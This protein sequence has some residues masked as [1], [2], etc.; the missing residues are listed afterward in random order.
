MNYYVNILT[1]VA[2]NGLLGLSVY[3]VLSTGQLTLGNAGFMGVGAFASALLSMHSGLPLFVSVLVGALIAMVVAIP[4]GY[5]TLR[6][7]GINL[8]IVTLGF[9]QIVVVVAQNVEYF[10]GALGLKNIPQ[11][12]GTV[13][14]LL[15]QQIETMP[16]GLSFDKAANLI[17][18]VGSVLVLALVYLFIVRQGR[19]RVG[20]AFTA[21]RA[22]EVSAAAAGINPTSYKVLAFA[23][24]AFIAGLAGGLTAHTTYYI[25]APDFGFTRAVEMLTYVVVGGTLLPVGAVFGAAV[26]LLLSEG[27]RDIYLFGS[28]LSDFR[29]IIFGALMMIMMLLRPE[30]LLTPGLFKLIRKGVVKWIPFWRSKGSRNGSE[31]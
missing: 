3:L 9:S 11:F 8:A 28:R 26:L 7:R 4:L 24:G 30:G 1:F 13:Q 23:Q 2:I 20:R 27:I 16:N 31:G 22:D 6:L 14:R 12:R 21:I 19:G 29:P 5:A 10:G 17:V 15:R 18:M 25:G